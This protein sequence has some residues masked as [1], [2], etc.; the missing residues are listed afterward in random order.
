MANKGKMIGT[1]Q[2]FGAVNTNTPAGGDSEGSGGEDES[3]NLRAQI[4]DMA[5]EIGIYVT[6]KNKAESLVAGAE[7]AAKEAQTKLDEATRKADEKLFQTES[8]LNRIISLLKGE[9]E[10]LHARLC[11]MLSA[12]S[13]ESAGSQISALRREVEKERLAKEAAKKAGD[14]LAAKLE[15]VEKELDTANEWV[16]EKEAKKPQHWWSRKKKDEE[17]VS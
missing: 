16:K 11:V 3:R 4:M 6:A 9:V 17:V 13:A 14:D 10:E 2:Q 15:R 5:A 12:G 7:L 8:E 1:Q